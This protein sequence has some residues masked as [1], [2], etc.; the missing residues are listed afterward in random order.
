MSDSIYFE[1]SRITLTLIGAVAQQETFHALRVARQ[2]HEQ[3]EK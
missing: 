1:R 3:D 2:T